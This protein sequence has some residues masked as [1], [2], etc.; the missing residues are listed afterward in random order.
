ML[1]TPFV[2]QYSG[3]IADWLI[4]TRITQPFDPFVGLEKELNEGFEED[5]ENR[6]P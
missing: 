1:L 3:K 2:I 6:C 4:R 5:L